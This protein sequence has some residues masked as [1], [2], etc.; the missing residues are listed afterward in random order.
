MMRS[1]IF[2]HMLETRGWK[3]RAFLRYLR[4]FKYAAFSWNRGEFLE[5]YYTLM[6][7]L[8]DIVDGDAPLPDGYQD[9]AHYLL[10]KIRFS[11]KPVNPKDEV[12]FL[13][14]YCFELADRFGENFEA[15][16]RD[17]L[18]SLL[19]DANRRG[20]LIIF[21]ESELMHHFHILD[22]RGTIKATLKVFNE[23]PEKYLLLEP[24]GMA[25]RYQYDLEDF[26]ADIEAGYVNITIE[27]CLRFGIL[28]EDLQDKDS[29]GIEK[30][31]RYRS[32][33]GLALLE[34]H[35]QRLPEGNFSILARA[36]FPLVYRNPARNVFR[37][38][39]GQPYN[40]IKRSLTEINE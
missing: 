7:Y 24:L 39:L 37:N 1:R 27:E 8:D 11:K 32:K 4:M 35:A 40:T 26:E 9:S 33:K 28:H 36:T 29:P 31:F 30:W 21:P 22:I 15:E 14:L 19:F 18:G 2:K 23:N 34:E 38:I 5:C 6:R 13:M 3:Y 10:E 16:T 25:S 20:K 17:I 12:D